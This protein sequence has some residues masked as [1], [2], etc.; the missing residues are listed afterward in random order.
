MSLFRVDIYNAA[1]DRVGLGPLTQIEK[2]TQRRSLD[3]IGEVELTPMAIDAKTAECRAG[4][5]YRVYHQSYGELGRFYHA[6][7]GLSA[8]TSPKMVI[9]AYDDLI[10]LA[11][12]NVYF[13]RNFNYTPVDQVI[14]SLAALAG[15]S[16]TVDAGIGNTTV[17]YE[18]ES[19]FE[20]LDVL[21][22]RW[23]QHFRRGGDRALEFG[24]FGADSGIKLVRAESAPRE[25]GSNDE[26]AMVTSLEIT[27]ES[28]QVINRLI[29]VG[30]GAGTTQ[31]TLEHVT[32]PISGYP[33][34][35]GVNGD[36][37][38]FYY[39][40]D[41]ASQAENGL[42]ERPFERSDIRPLTNST[43]NLQNA[44]NALYR[45]ALAGLLKWIAPRTHYRVAVT[46]LN[47]ARLEPGDKVRLVYRGVAT[48]RGRPYKWVEVNEL[49]WVMDI[50]ET[51]SADGRQ[52][53]RLT[54][55]TAA[56]RRTS[57]SDVLAQLMR[58]AK[59]FKTHVQPNLTHSPTGPYVKRMNTS[60]AAQFNVRLK[61]E[62]LAINRAILRFITEPLRSSVTAS[63]AGSAH[64]HEVTIGSSGSHSHNVTIG[65]SG[66]HSHSVTIGSS[67]AH[68]HTVTIASSGGH[69][70][71]LIIKAYSSG[72]NVM[73][74]T[75]AAD[76]V[77]S[78]GSDAAVETTVE[79]T[80]GHSHG[81]H[82]SSSDSHSH[83]ATTTT[84]DS[85]SHPT[86]TSDG[87][88]HSHPATATT[89]ESEHTHQ[90]IY[91][92]FEDSVYPHSISVAINGVDR[93]GVLG[94]PF[95]PTNAGVDIEVDITEYLSRGQDNT[96]RFTCG[97][98]QGE[99]TCL[100][101][102]LLTIQA[103]VVS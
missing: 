25:L 52:E 73:Y 103:I 20:A 2:I 82:S 54:V 60:H 61:D 90:F 86:T 41:A 38:A 101:E 58:D 79:N 51:Y 12:K 26:I 8:G 57:D 83:P 19:V 53:V 69:Y 74:Y 36:G 56:E 39:I 98:G 88:A 77:R 44:A 72:G 84:S 45:A 50:E 46:K 92:L 6:S 18:G 5:S 93:T 1:G 40:E 22:D 35:S 21:R 70:H 95:A 33:V 78:G 71:Y 37:S 16:A 75:G 89:E 32:A 23:G 15:W 102:C 9:K 97:S 11:R 63:A 4:R 7:G 31:L 3:K 28:D 13:R 10:E 47:P 30:A 80:G 64:G 43:A 68:S 14:S 55:A 27:E 24:A 100:V 87:V 48:Y 17:S 67:G 99:I 42:I 59:V 81:A 62:V 29:P 76:Y 85:H 65:S 34:L 96:V 49:L 91:G 94:G 66:S